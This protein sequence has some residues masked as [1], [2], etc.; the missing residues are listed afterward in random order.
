MP[1][2]EIVNVLATSLYN[3]RQSGGGAENFN[4]MHANELEN[5]LSYNA[6]R[7]GVTEAARQA[8]T[9]QEN[10]DRANYANSLYAYGVN[11][12]GATD[13]FRAAKAQAVTKNID[14]LMILGTQAV[15]VKK[16]QVEN[17]GDKF[18]TDYAN[19]NYRAHGSGIGTFS[20]SEYR[21]NK[22]AINSALDNISL[23]QSKY[24]TDYAQ[25]AND[26]K[27]MNPIAANAFLISKLNK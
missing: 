16:S 23:L 19:A 25:Y 12:A 22:D 15:D 11:E 13:A 2:L 6:Q 8:N 3:I 26:V 17:Q 5:D 9:T 7:T 20:A 4:A 27:G 21:N 10:Q 24:P 14:N 18:T 1:V